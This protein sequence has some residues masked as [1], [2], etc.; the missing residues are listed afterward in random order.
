M[1]LEDRAKEIAGSLLVPTLQV[2]RRVRA[3][4]I[5]SGIKGGS[6]PQIV[7]CDDDAAYV[8]KFQNNDQAGGRILA[9]DLLGTRLAELLA[10]PVAPSAIVDV[11]EDLIRCS[12]SARIQIDFQADLTIPC[13]AG[14]C[15]GSQLTPRW[16]LG[17]FAKVFDTISDD[18]FEILQNKRD[19]LGMLVFDKWTS[20]E[21]C[22]QVVFA[23]DRNARRCR[24]VM[25]DQGHCFG[26]A[27]WNFDDDR[28]MRL[29]PEYRSTYS[30]AT[31]TDFE[32]WLSR[33]ENGVTLDDITK[34]ASEI[35]PEW[36]AY[37]RRALAYLAD[38]LD[39]RRSIV[40]NLVR[41]VVSSHPYI[42]GE[43]DVS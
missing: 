8:V 21:D 13:Q 30:G 16:C 10:L 35:P 36:Y 27:A 5:I 38:R 4:E 15:F 41:K 22:R 42:L 25:I 12:P 29:L 37:H 2:L 40:R 24:A 19:F 28:T 1:D 11:P 17:E 20:N 3:V 18:Q 33:L 31:I 7:V 34:L 26:A 14:L 32:P 43:I 9:N 6:N 23:R 39:H